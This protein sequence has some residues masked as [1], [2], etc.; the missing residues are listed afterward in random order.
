MT[1]VNTLNRSYTTGKIPEHVHPPSSSA[2]QSAAAADDGVF[3][4]D[5]H[6]GRYFGEIS[7]IRHVTRTAT[8]RTLTRCVM[9]KLHKTD[10]DR[11]FHDAPEALADFHIRFAREH[12]D[13]KHVLCVGFPALC[14]NS[15]LFLMSFRQTRIIV[16]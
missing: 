5:L 12:V 1:Q 10:F 2:S 6:A 7:L 16:L 15:V 11:L 8:V 13:L 3:L 14:S 9:L 4:N